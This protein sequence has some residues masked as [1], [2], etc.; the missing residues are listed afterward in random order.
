M[1]RALRHRDF[2]LFSLT[3]WCST[4]G[5]WIQR[6]AVGWL[7]WELTHSAAWL[8]GIALAHSLPALFLIPIAGAVADR[9]DRLVLM[10]IT[11]SASI[12]LNGVIAYLVIVDLIT[13][14]ILFLLIVATGIAMAF[15]MPARMTVAPALVPRE[16][17]SAAIAV[18]AFLF[19]SSAFLG[20]AVAGLVVEFWGLGPAF[21][22]NVLSFVP[23]YVILYV[24]RL[25][26]I[27]QRAQSGRSLFGD[28][29]EGFRYC[30]RHAGI[31]PILLATILISLLSRPLIELLPGFVGDIFEAGPSAL[32][33]LM[34]AMG[35]GGMAGSLWM[36]NRNRLAG[37]TTIYFAGAI[38]VAA[39]T[40]LF[41]TTTS[42]AV[43]I[44]ILVLLGFTGSAL[45]NASQTLIQSAVDGSFRARVMALLSLSH[46]APALGAMVL[47]GAAS[48]F[49]LQI[50]VAAGAAFG[51]AVILWIARERRTIAAAVE[52]TVPVQAE[53]GEI[54]ATRAGI[55]E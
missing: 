52:M 7:T 45:S 33:N 2:A 6:L 38:G 9:V 18:N 42:L 44:G 24:I 25:K 17:L 28:A 26:N 31:G 51:L 16:D 36:A 27:D 21:I 54:S 13:V 48:V 19:Q 8:G 35:I 15:N 49:G 23:F 22:I 30:R 20:P 32:G 5:F 1:A 55:A 11:Q 39:L 10:R 40:I 3:S 47:G 43:G 41:A 50:S 37:T 14:E 29:M 46:Q 4:M 34:S 12:L 53:T